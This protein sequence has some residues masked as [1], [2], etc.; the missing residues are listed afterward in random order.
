LFLINIFN[1]CILLLLAKVF[2]GVF[3]LATGNLLLGAAA[4]WYYRSYTQKQKAA[5]EAKIAA[6]KPVLKS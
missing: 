5:E 3:V 1:F 2:V 4:F 6:V